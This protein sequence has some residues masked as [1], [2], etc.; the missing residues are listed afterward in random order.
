M[1]NNG[2][3]RRA[4]HM[5]LRNSRHENRI[6]DVYSLTGHGREDKKKKKKKKD[7]DTGMHFFALLEAVRQQ[8]WRQ[9]ETAG[10]SRS[11]PTIVVFLYFSI[12]L[13]LA[14]SVCWTDRFTLCFFGQRW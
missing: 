1:T 9:E 7:K 10:V 3:T 14:A 11:G 4:L 2:R 13:S 5:S 8:S 6:R 12:L